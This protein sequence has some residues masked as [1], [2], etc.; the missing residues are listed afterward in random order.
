MIPRLFIISIIVVALVGLILYSQMRPEPQHVSGV[1]EADEIRVG[2]RI[3]GRVAKVH[4]EEGQEVALGAP[5]IE[6]EPF[7]L[8][9]REQEAAHQLASR[10]ADYQRLITGLRNEE[11]AQAKARFDQL[12]AKLALLA[13][14]PRKQEIEAANA[15]VGAAQSELKLA[16]T[17][18][19]RHAELVQNNALSRAEFDRTSESL[20]AARAMLVVRRKE[21]ELLELGSRDEEIAAA[22]AAVEE[23]SQAWRMAAKGFRREEVEAA[24][25]ARDAAQATLNAILEQKKEL[26]IRSPIDGVVDSLELQPGDMIAA[27]AP[28][29]SIVDHRELWV[30]AYVPQN[31]VGLRVGQRLRVAVDSF[32]D[33]NFTGRISYISRQAE[34]TPSNVQTPEERAK[35]VFRI[36]VVIEDGLDVLRPGLTADVSLQPIGEAQ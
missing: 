9:E 35:Q 23:A 13:A 26:Q 17:V 10:E 34:F 5:L 4:V 1:I 21:L 3:G 22:R 15:R 25:A 7:D 12:A 29:L 14:G 24:R 30:R 11:V 16:E 20:E 8:L 6:V 2:S 33:R 18:Y 27:G 19:K 31:R 28:T 32:P 36:K